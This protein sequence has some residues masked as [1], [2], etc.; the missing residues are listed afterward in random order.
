MIVTAATYAE[1]ASD[2]TNG[3]ADIQSNDR[4]GLHYEGMMIPDVDLMPLGPVTQFSLYWTC[5]YGS[6]NIM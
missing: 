6:G 1:A 2:G 3:F 4:V 5:V